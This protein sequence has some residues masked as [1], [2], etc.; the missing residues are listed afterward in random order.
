MKNIAKV[1][2]ERIYEKGMTI[3][4]VAERANIAPVALSAMLNDRQKILALDFINLCR[5]LD[6]SPDD[7]ED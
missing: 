6:L 5:V 1:F 3:K 4:A 7:F 2:R